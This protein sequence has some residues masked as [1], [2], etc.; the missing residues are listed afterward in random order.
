MIRTDKAGRITAALDE[1]RSAMPTDIR[2]NAG[3]AIFTPDC[4]KR[5][6]AELESHVIAGLGYFFAAA[7]ANP[8]L[9]EQVLALKLQD[10]RLRVVGLGH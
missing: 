3:F 9:A 4:H 10:A 2:Q 1:D 7:N 5:L 6:V 8:V